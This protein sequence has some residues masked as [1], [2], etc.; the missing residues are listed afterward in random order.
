MVV[1]TT[2]SQDRGTEVK[3][4]AIDTSI[5]GT[6][7]SPFEKFDPF[8]IAKQGTSLKKLM[9][10][11]EQMPEQHRS[12][13]QSA[14]QQRAASRAAV[15][16]Q[17]QATGETGRQINASKRIADIV[18]ANMVVGKD[19]KV[20]K[21]SRAI[22]N[23]MASEGLPTEAAFK[24]LSDAIKTEHEGFKTESDKTD[25]LRA[26]G[27]TAANFM[28]NA[29]SPEE[30]MNM[31]KAFLDGDSAVVG[32][33]K[34]QQFYQGMFGALQPGED[35]RE[36]AKRISTSI[37]IS[38]LQE[39][40]L[41]PGG[42]S[43]DQVDPKS[44]LN[45]KDRKILAAMGINVPEGT[46]REQLLN[47]APFKKMIEGAIPSEGTL[48]SGIDEAAQ[49]SVA[50][51]PYT[52]ALGYEAALKQA[53]AIG[54]RVGSTV[55]EAIDKWIGQDPRRQVVRNALNDYNNRNNA[56][57]KLADGVDAAFATLRTEEGKLRAAEAA[58]RTKATSTNLRDAAA[59]VTPAAKPAAKPA[60]TARLK[61][62]TPGVSYEQY[63]GK[64]YLYTGGNANSGGSWKKM[65]DSWKPKE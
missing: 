38:E 2:S 36:A 34:A 45:A 14:E 27:L 51:Q 59:G 52:E 43:T 26:Q 32:P 35:P 31:A 58:G 61:K 22:A 15:A 1:Y 19:G 9:L 54:T 53:I 11:T 33:E 6:L 39:R 49:A 18:K 21:N 44:A 62:L 65:P 56:S 64:Y 37:S 17:E 13:M 42:L 48:V 3:P 60:A 16:A 46:S 41:I 12:A 25:W 30:A 28:R 63:G 23:Q 7:E 57:V 20:N 10:E 47:L 55:E 50:R 5:Y 29:K 24:Y 8:A 4:M 40:N